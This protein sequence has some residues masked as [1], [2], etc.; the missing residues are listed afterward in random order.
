MGKVK[1]LLFVLLTLL[2]VTSCATDKK[3]NV[4]EEFDS[5]TIANEGLKFFGEK[6]GIYIGTAITEGQLNDEKFVE[7]VKKNCNYIT[8]ENE[9]KWENIHPSR[10]V[11]NFKKTDKLVAFAK[12]N[13]MKIRG[14][15]LV[16]HSQNPYWIAKPGTTAEELKETMK[17][18]ISNVMTY[19]KGQV[20]DWDVVNEAIA[21][22]GEL[23]ESIWQLIIGDE[24]IEHAF[25]CAYEADPNAKLYINDYNIE[26]INPKSNKLY[27]IVKN[28]VAK[29][30]P[31]HGVGFQFHLDGRWEPDYVSI[32]ANFERFKKLGLDIQITELDV[33]LPKNYS[34]VDLNRQ[35]KIYGELMKIMLEVKGSAF[36]MWGMTDKYSWVPSF[37]S[38]FGG[39]LI[40]DEQYNPKPAYMKLKE[41]LVKSK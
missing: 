16:W 3:A 39:A 32:R 31:I 37:F 4:K 40:F 29:K 8:P 13:N 15:T 30:V 27:E 28:L 14:H 19:Y 33:R 10:K 7:I 34:E 5:A 24:Y 25:K 41:V 18:H 22:N 6:R 35:A 20:N 12:E 17:V 1:G 36:I 21:D 2:F 38:G 23:R 11:Y 26:D 9:F